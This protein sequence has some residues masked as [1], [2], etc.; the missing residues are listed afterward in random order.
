MDLKGIFN[1]VATLLYQNRRD[2]T[3]QAN[4][5]ASHKHKKKRFTFVFMLSP[6]YI[7]QESES[8]N[9]VKTIYAVEKYYHIDTGHKPM[10]S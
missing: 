5:F 4:Q 3:L 9:Q 1:M 7:I 10:L 8:G 2:P 6:R